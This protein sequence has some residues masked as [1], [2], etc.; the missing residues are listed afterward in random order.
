MVV[1]VVMMDR[2]RDE[3]T[4]KITQERLL[5][6]IYSHDLIDL[7]ELNIFITT[8]LADEESKF[9]EVTYGSSGMNH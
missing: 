5:C 9:K 6:A 3:E 1:V 4:R 2:C 7:S 8:F